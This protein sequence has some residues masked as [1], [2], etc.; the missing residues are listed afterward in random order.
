MQ[1]NVLYRVLLGKHMALMQQYGAL[2]IATP[3][4]AVRGAQTG[5]LSIQGS[6]E[7]EMYTYEALLKVYRALSQQ[8]KAHMQEYSALSMYT[9]QQ[10]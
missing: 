10:P 9:Q 6:F 7:R 8:Y 2:P 5:R 1:N 4:A 3:A